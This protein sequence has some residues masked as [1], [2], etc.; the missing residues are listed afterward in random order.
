MGAGSGQDHSASAVWFAALA[1]VI[2]LLPSCL[3]STEMSSASFS[4]SSINLAL[5]LYL[6]LSVLFDEGK[7]VFS[8]KKLKINEWQKQTKPRKLKCAWYSL[9]S[10]SF[11][12]S[13]PGHNLL[14]GW[15]KSWTLSE[16]WLPFFLLAVCFNTS[17][18]SRFLNMYIFIYIPSEHFALTE[19]IKHVLYTPK[20]VWLLLLKNA[21]LYRHC[22]SEY[23]DLFT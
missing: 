5:P 19:R 1:F 2:L 20:G 9:Q 17:T 18:S 6:E 16:F 21:C 14:Y 3:G 15:N 13:L 4:E 8:P 22:V 12:S 7:T 23:G 11:F 10:P